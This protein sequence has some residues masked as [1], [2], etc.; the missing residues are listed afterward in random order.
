MHS[1]NCLIKIG[2]V[3]ADIVR[4]LRDLEGIRETLDC[5]KGEIF[6]F[7]DYQMSSVTCDALLQ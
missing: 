7:V 4:M 3:Y 1:I 2:S 6:S 5:C